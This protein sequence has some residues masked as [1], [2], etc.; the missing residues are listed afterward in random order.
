MLPVETTLQNCDGNLNYQ[1]SA[2]FPKYGNAL[3]HPVSLCT[4]SD[5]WKYVSGSSK[6]GE[7]FLCRSHILALILVDLWSQVVWRRFWHWYY[8]II[9]GRV[10]KN[11]CETLTSF[12]IVYRLYTPGVVNRQKSVSIKI[13]SNQV[14]LSIDNGNWWKSINKIAVSNRYYRFFMILTIYNGK[15]YIVVYWH[16]LNS[17]AEKTRPRVTTD[18]QTWKEENWKLLQTQDSL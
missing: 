15:S 5:R 17:T 6:L 4:Y 10:G 1:L 7:R 12:I 8:R 18:Q 3:F 16:K 11:Q 9:C 13:E 2:R 14:I